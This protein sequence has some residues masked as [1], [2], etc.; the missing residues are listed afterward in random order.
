MSAQAKIVSI[1]GGPVTIYD[2]TLSPAEQT[3]VK[4]GETIY[5]GT[6]FSLPS[7]TLMELK[8]QSSRKLWRMRGYQIWTFTVD[9][10]SSVP[11]AEVVPANIN[12]PVTY[13]ALGEQVQNLQREIAE[14]RLELAG[15]YQ[16]RPDSA[17]AH[18]DRART[19]IDGLSDV[20]DIGDLQ[21]RFNRVA[22]FDQIARF[23]Q[24]AR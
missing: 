20:A 5:A 6:Q 19:I 23:D 9:A 24:V 14:L 15:L 2:R 8:L 3:Q 18:L 13:E 1:E 21:E 17:S 12:R 7:N 4:V 11:G 22:R 16:D 10:H